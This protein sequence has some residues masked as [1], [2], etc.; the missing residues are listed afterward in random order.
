M[1]DV[2]GLGKPGKFHINAVCA[3]ESMTIMY[4]SIAYVAL[5]MLFSTGLGW[6]CRKLP[7]NYKVIFLINNFSFKLTM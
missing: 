7:D 3:P 5:L 1:E 6:K 2:Y 4:A